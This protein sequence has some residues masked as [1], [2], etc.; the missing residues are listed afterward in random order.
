MNQLTTTQPDRSQFPSP[1]E[2]N[3]L[4]EFGSMAV[5]S[6]L[7][8]TSI[9]TPEKAV[10]IALKGREIGI[11]PLQA[12]SG[13]SVVQGKPT[14]SSELMLALIYRDIPGVVIDYIET[15]DKAC[16]IEAKRPGGRPTRFSFTL[17]DAK[18]AGLLGK[19]PWLSY[20]AAMLRARCISAMA[21]AVFPDALAGISYTPEELG[22]PVN[23]EGA[24]IDV[25]HAKRVHEAPAVQMAA[26]QVGP[27]AVPAPP[28]TQTKPELSA[29][30]VEV[31]ALL[32]ERS[33]EWSS[34]E[35]ARYLHSRFN[36]MRVEDLADKDYSTFLFVLNE[37]DAATAFDL[38]KA[39]AYK[40]TEPTDENDLPV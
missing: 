3:V 36:V 34:S 25:Q 5:K 19:G 17:E 13:I 21:R 1:Q 29:R 7:L 2:F 30:Q 6:G 23:E 12:F 8:P 32:K 11:P 33:K 22:A 39:L 31:R 16:I 26:E 28:A 15:S 35:A 4:K 9:N 40:P 37:N 24:V 20:P 10:I 18:R 38:L 27:P 14:M